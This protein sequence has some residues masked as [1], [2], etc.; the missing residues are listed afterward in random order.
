MTEDACKEGARLICDGCRAALADGQILCFFSPLPGGEGGTHLIVKAECRQAFTAAEACPILLESTA[1]G[2]STGGTSSERKR[3]SAKAWLFSH[4]VAC[5][6]CKASIGNVMALGP[7]DEDAICFSTTLTTLQA[8][9]PSTASKGSRTGAP[10]SEDGKKKAKW[11]VLAVTWPYSLMEQRHRAIFYGEGS[12]MPLEQ[13]GN[14][15]VDGE[16]AGGEQ[17]DGGPAPSGNAEESRSSREDDGQW[18]EDDSVG[19]AKRK[20]LP[21]GAHVPVVRITREHLLGQ[22]VKLHHLSVQRPRS[23]QVEAFVA[24][25][26]SQTIVYLPTGAGKTLVAAMMASAMHRLNPSRIILF[27]VDRV[28]LAYQQ[29]AYLAAQ[30]GLRTRPICGENSTENCSRKALLQCP[31]IVVTAQVLINWVADGVLCMRSDV[32]LLILDEVHHAIKAHAYVA[33]IECA[34][35]PRSDSKCCRLARRGPTFWASA[36]LLQ[37]PR[38]VRLAA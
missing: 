10:S 7:R 36:R 13:A 11:G 27:V 18:E 30:T 22:E 37:W 32:S 2:V 19:E 26:L 28:P 5:R 15:Q 4:T 16:Q 1:D 21:A 9:P 17:A 12:Q 23:Y 34:Y 24:A 35:P 14:G 33:L 29:A 8:P 3:R 31:L 6:A 20:R 38:S 25:A